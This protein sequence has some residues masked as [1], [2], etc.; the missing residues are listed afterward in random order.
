MTVW[1][2]VLLRNLRS[3]ATMKMMIMQQGH[4]KERWRTVSERAAEAA[5]KPTKTLPVPTH[6]GTTY[7]HRRVEGENGR[8]STVDERHSSVSHTAHVSAGGEPS[9]GSRPH[10]RLT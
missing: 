8:K 1:V 4:E 9:S 2:Q 7:P 6:F 10:R 3:G 5:R